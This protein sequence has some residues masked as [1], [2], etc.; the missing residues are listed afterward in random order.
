MKIKLFLKSLFLCSFILLKSNDELILQ[1]AENYFLEK[2]WVSAYK[3]YNLLTYK[4]GAVLKNMGIC[5][6]NLKKYPQA[7]IKFKQAFNKVKLQHFFSLVELEKQTYEKLGKEAP[8]LIHYFFKELFLF[9]PFTLIQI[10]FLILLLML[11]Y[12]FI[13]HWR[14]SNFTK[15]EARFLKKIGFWIIFFGLIWYVKLLYFDKYQAIV[16]KPQVAV[17]AGPEKTFHI[18]QKLDVA[19]DIVI[20]GEKNSMYQI[21]YLK[22]VGWIDCDT[23]ELINNYE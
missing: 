2:K 13:R 12:F 19:D 4:N 23:V 6:F 14:I 15:K 8:W 17:Y 9:I 16:I 7:L 20:S 22:T 10:I 5:C 3:N 11:L 21:Q 18:I 1:K